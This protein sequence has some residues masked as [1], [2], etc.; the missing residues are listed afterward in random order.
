MFKRQDMSQKL[1][2][3]EKNTIFTL[4]LLLVKQCHLDLETSHAYKLQNL[5][6]LFSLVFFVLVCFSYFFLL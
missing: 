4:F 1:L 3:T 2:Q 6:A 5:N